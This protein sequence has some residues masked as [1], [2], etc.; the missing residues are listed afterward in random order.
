LKK[1]T[2]KLF[3]PLGHGLFRQHGPNESKFFCFF[4]FTKRSAYFSKI[5][6]YFSAHTSHQP[7]GL[8]G[9]ATSLQVPSGAL[10]LRGM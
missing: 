6:A 3:A 5:R 10:P 8:I 7:P 4:L 2:K 9:P 1:R